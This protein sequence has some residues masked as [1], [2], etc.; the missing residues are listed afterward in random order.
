MCDNFHFDITGAPLDKCLDLAMAGAAGKKVVARSAERRIVDQP[1]SRPRLILYWHEHPKATMLPAP[2][3]EVD[4]LTGFVKSWL[5]WID[6]GPE[7]D[8]D[9]DNSRGW[10]VYNE[11]W[12]RIGDLTY[13][14]VA[15]EPT[16]LWH[17]K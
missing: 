11:Q 16:W 7:P 17:G 9:G 12:A 3:T 2:I 13:S 1:S 15:I 14:F 8:H 6:Y 4:V 5:L 10:R